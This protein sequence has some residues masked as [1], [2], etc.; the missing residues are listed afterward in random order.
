MLLNAISSP[1]YPL[2][3]IIPYRHFVPLPPKEEA[4]IVFARKRRQWVNLSVGYYFT[5]PLGN[6]RGGENFNEI[7]HYIRHYAFKQN[8]A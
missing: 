4:I 8:N 7:R 5:E 1:Y 6:Y 2:P 3:G